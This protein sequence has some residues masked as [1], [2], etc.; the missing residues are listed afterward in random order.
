MISAIGHMRI[1]LLAVQTEKQLP[2][3]KLNMA[4]TFH[5]LPMDAWPNL[6]HQSLL[7][8]PPG[9]QL[10]SVPDA[11]AKGKGKEHFEN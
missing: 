9:S 5:Q 3:K 4:R 1:T 11:E 6:H 7:S 8:A 2:T 10:H